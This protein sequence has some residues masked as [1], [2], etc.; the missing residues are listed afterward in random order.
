MTSSMETCIVIN[1]RS[2][3]GKHLVVRLLKLG[4]WIVKVAGADD[5]LKL[6]LHD[7]DCDLPLNRAVST[8]R[9]AYVSVVTYRIHNIVTWNGDRSG[10]GSRFAIS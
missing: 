6:D 5:S 9:A 10:T 8:G 4:H 7:F 1:G 2:F 3:V